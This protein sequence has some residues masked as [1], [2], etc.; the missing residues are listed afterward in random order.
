MTHPIFR[1]NS[2][3]AQIVTAVVSDVF[4]ST[5]IKAVVTSDNAA[6]L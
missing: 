5:T 4:T 2:E 6:L 3:V 1:A